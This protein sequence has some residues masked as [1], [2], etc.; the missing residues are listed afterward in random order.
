MSEAL[1]TSPDYLNHSSPE[2]WNDQMEQAGRVALSLAATFAQAAKHEQGN[3]ALLALAE[4][5][6]AL[7]DASAPLAQFNQRQTMALVAPLFARAEQPQDVLGTHIDDL[8]ADDSDLSKILKGNGVE[9]VGDLTPFRIS[10]FISMP[11]LGRKR[12]D[13]LLAKLEE[14][15]IQPL[16]D[17]NF[18]TH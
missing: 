1:N 4:S 18:Y 13:R 11:K 8:F 14:I 17:A 15:G 3:P 5:V 6:L 2:Q 12:M 16:D 9:T 7:D 10:S